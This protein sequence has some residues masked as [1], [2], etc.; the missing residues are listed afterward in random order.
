MLLI[1]RLVMAFYYHVCSFINPPLSDYGTAQSW[2]SAQRQELCEKPDGQSAKEYG[3][4]PSGF[5]GGVPVC[6]GELAAVSVAIC[7]SVRLKLKR[8]KSSCKNALFVALGITGMP[9]W[10]T[11]RR[12]TCGPVTLCTLPMLVTSS[13]AAH[14]NQRNSIVL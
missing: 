9:C 2:S 7:W 10:T 1:A 11:Q 5:C 3:T 8:S 6:G 12:A 14:K 4:V 13:P